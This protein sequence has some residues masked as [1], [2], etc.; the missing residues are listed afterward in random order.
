MAT[1]T[2]A[3]AGYAVPSGTKTLSGTTAQT[4]A[5]T[6][7]S[8]GALRSPYWI[9]EICNLNDTAK[10]YCL[11]S[12]SAATSANGLVIYPNSAVAFP[13]NWLTGGTDAISVVGAD[14]NTFQVNLMP[15]IG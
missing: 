15:R 4:V 2:L 3:A 11:L 8:G 9:V 1:F 14:G 6:D 12:G 5:I 10:L 7:A 13:T